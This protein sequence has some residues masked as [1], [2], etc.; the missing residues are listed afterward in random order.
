MPNKYQ[1]IGTEVVGSDEHLAMSL[2]SSKAGMT[3]L[4]KGPLPFGPGKSVAVIGQAVS[5]MD[6][7]TGN[8]DGPLCPQG[9]SKCFPSIGEAVT[10]ANKGGTTTVVAG[11]DATQVIPPV[12]SLLTLLR[13]YLAHFFP[14]FPLFCAF[15]PPRRDGSNE[16][17]AGTQGQETVARAPKH[18]FAGLS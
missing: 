11:V 15:S 7:M 14:V 10:A 16:P 12:L 17:Q 4:K 9:G 1:K 2:E 13:P 6:A 3:L 5:D 18:R 8:Y